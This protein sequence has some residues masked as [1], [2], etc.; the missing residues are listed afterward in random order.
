MLLSH[1]V[2]TE[3]ITWRT[4]GPVLPS[5]ASPFVVLNTSVFLESS[6]WLFC[7]RKCIPNLDTVSCIPS[8]SWSQ[9]CHEAVS[10]CWLNGF[11][12]AATVRYKDQTSTSTILS[13]QFSPITYRSSFPRLR[14]CLCNHPKY[15]VILAHHTLKARSPRPVLL[16]KNVR[17]EPPRPRGSQANHLSPGQYSLY[18]KVLLSKTVEFV[19]YTN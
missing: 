18:S 17:N 1:G 6:G 7:L 16:F 4:A 12:E 5:S 2:V 9:L 13:Q 8:S 14:Q 11:L 15:L 3:L 10:G 19:T